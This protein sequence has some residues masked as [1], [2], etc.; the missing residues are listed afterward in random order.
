MVS[1]AGPQ[2]RT[3]DCTHCFPS[4]DTNG[5]WGQWSDWTDCSVNCGLGYRFR[6]RA[7]DSPLP[8]NNGADCGEPH[9]EME[10]CDAGGDLATCPNGAYHSSPVQLTPSPMKPQNKRFS[11]DAVKS[12]ERACVS[13]PGGTC[14][15]NGTERKVGTMLSLNARKHTGLHNA[16]G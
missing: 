3:D 1:L 6:S 14:F 10:R 5:G 15:W 8:E 9:S 12:C 16:R 2:G 13:F 4:G 7:C 11:Q